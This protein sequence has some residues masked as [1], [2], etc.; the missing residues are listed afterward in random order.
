MRRYWFYFFFFF[1]ENLL[2]QWEIFLVILT[3]E[4]L[5]SSTNFITQCAWFS[6]LWDDA[7]IFDSRIILSPHNA[8]IYDSRI[9]Y[10]WSR[11]III[12]PLNLSPQNMHTSTCLSSMCFINN[13]DWK[14]P[15]DSIQHRFYFFVRSLIQ[16]WKA[17]YGSILFFF[18]CVKNKFWTV[19]INKSKVREHEIHRSPFSNLWKMLR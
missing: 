5:H 15:I 9:I 18:Y 4:W 17:N 12:L 6:N 1:I 8:G 14:V 13:D 19:A 7:T 10:V 2:T 16:K 11:T 3:W